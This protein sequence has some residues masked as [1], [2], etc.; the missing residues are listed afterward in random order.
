MLT[1]VAGLAI[2]VV[3]LDRRDLGA[4]IIPAHDGP[5]RAGRLLVG[6][7]SL[8]TRLRARGTILGWAAAVLGLVIASLLGSVADMVADPEIQDLLEKL[9]GTTTGTV[10]NVYVATEVHFVAVAVAAAGIALVLRLVGL[11]EVGAGRGRPR[12]PH[13]PAELVRGARRPSGRAHHGADGAA[14]CG[15]RAGRPRRQ[16]RRPVLRGLRSAPPWPHCPPCG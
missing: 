15:G 14:R 3:V 4:G 8:V 2:A 16:R 7:F 13:Q 12:H 9:G 10:E 1:L 6:P 5:E 11:G